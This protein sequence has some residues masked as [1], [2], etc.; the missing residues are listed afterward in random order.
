MPA[1]LQ[2]AFTGGFL[3]SPLVS[4]QSWHYSWGVNI[5]TVALVEQLSAGCSKGAV[6]CL[7]KFLAI[8][9]VLYPLDTSSTPAPCLVTG[10]K[11]SLFGIIQEARQHYSSSTPDREPLFHSNIACKICAEVLEPFVIHI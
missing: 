3:H 7:G 11:V 6:T 4:P 9:T 8:V 5:S 10:G 1:L 2:L